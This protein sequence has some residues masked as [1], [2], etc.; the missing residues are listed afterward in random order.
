MSVSM[1]DAWKRVTTAAVLGALALGTATF[2]A[3]E[4]SPAPA[5]AAA[6][7]SAPLNTLTDKEK[8]DGWKLLFDGTTLDGWRNYKKQDIA[9]GWQVKDGAMECKNGGDLITKE[10]YGSFELSIDFKISPGGNSGIL[11][12]VTEQGD[13]PWNSAPEIQIL[14]FVPGGH[15]P[16]LAGWLYQLYQPPMDPKTSKPIDVSRHA[17]EWNTMHLLLKGPHF[18]ISLNGVKY[19]EGEMW[20]DDWNAR[21]AKSKFSKF[22]YFAK[23]KTGYINL[24]DHRSEVAFRNIKIKVLDEK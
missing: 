1:N 16:Q 8:A 14:D 19:E 12:H 2:A 9:S 6:T 3:D 4:K 17:G 21:V 18:E 7:D 11:F 22:P 10:Q 20:S 24:Q 23:A 13:K 15:E 5:A